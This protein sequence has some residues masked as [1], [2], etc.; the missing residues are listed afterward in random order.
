MIDN[1]TAADY[2]ELLNAAIKHA[3][4]MKK[5]KAEPGM[6]KL[7][8]RIAVLGTCSIQF[9]VMVLRY[10]L[11]L[12]GIEA[13]IYEGEYNGINMDVF[14]DNSPFYGFNPELVILLPYH[15]DI[16]IKPEYFEKEA[17]IQE[18]ADSVA[19][20]YMQ[21]WEKINERLTCHI[22]QA[23]I[24]L[25]PLR[26]M[27]C[28]EANYIFSESHFLKRVNL[29]FEKRHP[30]NVT[31]IDLDALAS[32]IGKYQWFNYSDYYLSKAGFDIK[33]IGAVV[34][35]FITPI[36]AIK[37]RVRKCLV[38]DLDN[39]LWGGV[40]SEEGCN[41]IRIDQNSAEGES[42]RAF[43]QYIAGLKSRGVILAVC[44]KNDEAI[45]KEPF[46]KNENMILRLEDISCFM[47]NWED[48]AT[49]IRRIAESL[50]IG[51]DSLVFV[52][53]N[54][55]ERQ[56]IREFLPSVLVVELPEDI[57]EYSL[58]LE[59]E[60][61]FDW[62]Q[63]TPEDLSRSASYRENQQREELK[64]S[65]ESYGEYLKNLEMKGCV[66][67]LSEEYADRFTQ[68]INKS[69]QFNLRT[70]RY[71]EAEIKGMMADGDYCL[72]YV[73]LS[74]RFSD[75]GLISCII[76]KRQ[77][78]VCFIDTWLMSCR[79]LKRDVEKM[80]AA[81]I[82]KQAE[83]WGCRYVKGEYLPTK[84]NGMVRSLYPDLGFV[85]AGNS[86][87]EAPEAEVY[88]LNLAEK[89]EWSYSIAQD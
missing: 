35:E 51:L 15:T 1:I 9:F 63:L 58:A 30:G 18:K 85:E 4:K 64:L 2:S 32:D 43:Q 80:A 41:G 7:Q 28:L 75:Y 84:K 46:E 77:G 53:D 69:N 16:V 59:R 31:V 38:M 25:P 42:Y 88:L 61:A 17:G 65:F 48:K 11:S 83:K 73:K 36:L 8:L 45:A 12:E 26:K 57:A 3:R 6:G 29:E 56:L 47:A 44:S 50:N 21:I 82:V 19:G 14:D 74:D 79:V 13:E 33:Y 22:L 34:K 27:G 52:D 54:P 49:N 37:G 5:H 67:E 10:L 78:E 20:M 55:V 66:S 86:G 39:T 81:A 71:C 72:L 70:R 24:V 40:V 89:H 60:K 62:I 87:S 76:L 68:L 23:N